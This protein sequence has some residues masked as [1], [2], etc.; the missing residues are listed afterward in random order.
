MKTSIIMPVHNQI[1]FTEKAVESLYEFTDEKDFELILIDNGSEPDVRSVIPAKAGIQFIRN[2]SNL[3]WCKALNQG[4]SQAKACDYILWANNDILFEKDWLP[5]MLAHFRP[6]VGAVGPVSNYVNGRQR[7]EIGQ[8]EYEEE[9][10]WL[11][12]FFLMFRNG[13][14]DAV[15][16][17]DE[18][19]HAGGCEEWDYIIRMQQ[20]LGLGCVIAR[21]VYIHHFGSRTIRETVARTDQEYSDYC[22]N[23][24]EILKDKWGAEFIDQW[25]PQKLSIPQTLSRKSPWPSN[26]KLGLAIPHTWSKI[27]YNTHLSLMA[28]RK[29]NM[30]IL[31]AGQGGEL[32]TKRENQILQGLARGCTHFLIGDGDMRYPENILIDLFKIV[33]EGADMAGGL[34]Y[35]GY[36]PYDPIAWHP[37]EDRMLIP[38]VDYIF[39]DVIDAGAAGCACLLVKKEVFEKLDRPWFQNKWE[40]ILSD[41]EKPLLEYEEGDHYFTRKATRAGFK[42]KILTKYDVDH[43]REFPVNREL[44]LTHGL[45]SRLGSWGT[46]IALFKKLADRNWIEREI[47]GA[48]FEIDWPLNQRHYEISLLY[49]FLLG[50]KIKDI[51]EIGTQNGGTAL[52]WAKLVDS[53]EGHVYCVDMEFPESK[54]YAKHELNRRILEIAGDSHSPGTADQIRSIIQSNGGRVDFLFIDG[55]H[56][57]AGVKSDFDSYSPLVKPGGW[58][59]FH[60]ILDTDCHRRQNCQV[61]RLWNEIKENY[62]HF[63]IVDPNHRESM[64]IGIL[65]QK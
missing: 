14:I 57:Y 37:T 49:N 21:D 8:A 11:I 4:F 40:K 54:I 28:M 46:I 15:G 19:F 55:D 62:N 65:Q 38:F 63:E 45:L 42:F 27:D 20:K 18:R 47:N 7:V 35:R 9:V 36:P 50:K 24:I 26:C 6:G 44:W 58:I 2:E 53:R 51:L 41:E 3:G 17:V 22:L 23:A 12:G 5:K 32:D 13:V 52:L 16:E 39:G 56:S 64:G 10:Q 25:L 43:L 34:C 59:A 31:E 60:D 30:D 48:S 61:S 1:E 33:G 29:P